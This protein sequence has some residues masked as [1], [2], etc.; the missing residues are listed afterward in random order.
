[1]LPA[2]DAEAAAAYTAGRYALE[3][4]SVK[5]GA[6]STAT[7]GELYG[8]VTSQPTSGSEIRNKYV[9]N[10]AA[11]PIAITCGTGMSAGFYKALTDFSIGNLPLHDGRVTRRDDA[12]HVFHTTEFYDARVTSL[13]LPTV[14]VGAKSAA[15]MVVG[16]D[17]RNARAGTAGVAQ[18]PVKR[19]TWT[20][21]HFTLRIDK[22]DRLPAITTKAVKVGAMTLKRNVIPPQFSGDDP[23][24]DDLEVSDLVVA[25]AGNNPTDLWGWHKDYLSTA[26]GRPGTNAPAS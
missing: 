21:G 16:F 18:A 8:L 20:T 17:A 23:T 22:T 7:G 15:H 3:L 12:G 25:F 6:P 13:Q 11:S 19:S 2:V 10:V 5:A 24:Y 14:E 4:D 9:T 26:T 1:M